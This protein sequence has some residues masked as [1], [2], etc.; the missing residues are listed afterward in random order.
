VEQLHSFVQFFSRRCTPTSSSLHTTV[1]AVAHH[2]VRRCTPTCSPCTQTCSPLHQR[3]RR[4]TPTC[5]PLHTSVFVVAHHRVRCVLPCPHVALRTWFARGGGT[6]PWHI[7]QQT[8][9]N[10]N[11]TPGIACGINL[12]YDFLPKM[13]KQK[14][15]QA[16]ALGKCCPPPPPPRECGSNVDLAVLRSVFPNDVGFT[17]Q[18]IFSRLFFRQCWVG[19]L[20]HWWFSR[21]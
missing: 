6:D 8:R 10:L 15:Y 9:M 4:C 1:F 7:G 14:G 12:K 5:S 17:L 18:S 19:V 3:V 13:L 2:R 11:P 21:V 20:D 16:W